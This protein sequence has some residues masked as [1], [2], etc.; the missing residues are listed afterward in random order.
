MNLFS[1]YERGLERLLERMNQ[2]HPRYNEVLTLQSRLAENI[3][4]A[5]VYGDTEIRRAERAQILNALNRL[6]LKHAET[7]FSGL[8]GIEDIDSFGHQQLASR[9][10][11]EGEHLRSLKK[12][13]R[14]AHGFPPRRV[15]EDFFLAMEQT[16]QFVEKVREK[17]SRD[18]LSLQL[19]VEELLAE[20]DEQLQHCRTQARILGQ[21]NGKWNITAEIPDTDPVEKLLGH[22]DKLV[23]CLDEIVLLL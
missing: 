6:A 2:N 5:R 20:A 12:Y 4:A 8:C 14:R 13:L 15:V 17:P 9:A 18:D 7:S 21:L 16:A 23:D 10:R 11:E 3:S 22:L 1:S 19:R